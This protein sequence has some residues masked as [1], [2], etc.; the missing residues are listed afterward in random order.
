MNVEDAAHAI[1]YDFPG[2]LKILAD[3]MGIH[4]RTV[5]NGKVNP[6]DK[7]MCLAWLRRF[8][9]SSSQDVSTSCMRWQMTLAMYASS[10]R[11]LPGTKMFLACWRMCVANSATSCAKIDETLFDKKVSRNEAK[12]LQRELLELIAAATHLNSKL[13]SMVQALIWDMQNA[14]R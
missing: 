1:T 9:C 3:R 14:S 12:E 8:G 11:I 10:V 4:G 6:A 5:F 2:G 13:E 7:G